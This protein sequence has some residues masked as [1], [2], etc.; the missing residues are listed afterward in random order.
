L[1]VAVVRSGFLLFLFSEKNRQNMPTD[2]MDQ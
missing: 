2:R 1:P